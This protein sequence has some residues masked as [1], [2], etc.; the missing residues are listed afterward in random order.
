MPLLVSELLT[1]N[2]YR[3]L[4]DDSHQVGEILGLVLERIVIPEIQNNIATVFRI[5]DVFIQIAG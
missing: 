2:V 4:D 3:L 5:T 1:F